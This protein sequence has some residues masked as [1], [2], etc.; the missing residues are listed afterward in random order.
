MTPSQRPLKVFLCHSSDDKQKVDELYRYLR[1]RRIKAW[2]AEN[3]L[4]GGQDWQAEILKAL[5]TSDAVIVCLT[6]NFVG[7]EG[8]LQKEMKFA[9]D[10][11]LE[12]PEG[13]IYLIPV[14]FEEC[15]IPYVLKR[16]K[17]VDLFN[18]DGYQHLMGS[19]HAREKVI[20]VLQTNSRAPE[21][22][23][24]EERRN[25]VNWVVHHRVLVTALVLTF[26]VLA[27]AIWFVGGMIDN[28]HAR[29]S[30][31]ATATVP[32]AIQP[33]SDISTPVCRPSGNQ[34]PTITLKLE[35]VRV[36][37]YGT[38]ELTISVSDP[39]NDR[40]EILAIT[41]EKGQFPNGKE[42]PYR[43]EAPGFAGKDIITVL[44]GDHECRT[45]AEI[46]INIE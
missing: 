18:K 39:E 46:T 22:L 3:D 31:E 4:K 28:S 16:Y 27:L 21:K 15:E 35:P 10:K 32:A 38:A 2:I 1:S 45:E 12:V 23:K 40:Y 8:H 25:F 26:I 7:K 29:T 43:Y 5:E 24:Q 41:A 17:S 11:T 36:N 34:S 20:N 42:E 37:V 13:G 6:T 9:L 44:V 19:L 30:V 14:R 33:V